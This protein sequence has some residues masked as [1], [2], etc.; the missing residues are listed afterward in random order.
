MNPKTITRNFGQQFTMLAKICLHFPSFPI[1]NRIESHLL[2]VINVFTEAVERLLIFA[3]PGDL[4]SALIL[5]CPGDTVRPV[6]CPL[7]SVKLY[8]LDN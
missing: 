7:V 1:M 3:F 5:E 6:V 4:F 8:R 2:Q